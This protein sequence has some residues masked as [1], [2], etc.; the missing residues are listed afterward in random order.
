[1]AA[2]VSEAKQQGIPI[3][4]LAGQRASLI[5]LVKVIGPIWYSTLYVQGQRLWNIP[6]LPF[7]FNACLGILVFCICHFYV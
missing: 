2:M 1:M 5:A 7:M 6:S 3:G 4:E